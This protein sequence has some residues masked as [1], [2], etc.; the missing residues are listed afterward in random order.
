MRKF[1]IGILGNLESLISISILLLILLAPQVFPPAFLSLFG[2]KS[3][4]QAQNTATYG[5]VVTSLSTTLT[6][7][8]SGTSFAL[9]GGSASVISWSTSFTGSPNPV[10]MILEGSLDNSTFFTIGTSTAIAGDLQTTG[11]TAIKFVRCSQ[12][13][14]TGAGTTTCTLT[15]QRGF[16]LT[17]VTAGSGGFIDGTSGAPS[18]YSTSNPTNGFFF[19]SSTVISPTQSLTLLSGKT[20]ITSSATNIFNYPAIATTNTPAIRLTNATLATAGVP[21]Q[22]SPG[23]C[24]D[25][26]G[27]RTNATAAAQSAVVC[28]DLE[29]AQGT[30]NPSA[31][32]TFK[33]SVNGG[34]FSTIFAINNFGSTTAA[35][36]SAMGSTA[37]LL[38]G[39]NTVF[40]GAVPTITSGFGTGPTIVGKSSAFRVTIGT[41]GDTTGVI[42]FNNT[43]TNAPA[44]TANNE[45]TGNLTR[46]V[47][48]TTGVTINAIMVA[49]DKITVTCLGY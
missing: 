9:P 33:Y 21:A 46:A 23:F 45:T 12:V 24:F 40:S 2:I 47:S 22:Y 7:A 35:G 32:L 43:Y 31:I 8:V 39:S 28:I 1:L 4:L 37:V 27:W 36:N 3:T 6:T 44:C 41:G 30:A 5:T 38:S 17:N 26:S 48:T 29:P 13:S 49:A 11:F 16:N 20:L 42:A 14:K 15:T 19:P 18:I 34:A 25:G 10:S